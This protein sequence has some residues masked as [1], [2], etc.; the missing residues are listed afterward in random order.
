MHHHA[1]RLNAVTIRRK[2]VMLLHGW[3]R[4]TE[5]V[6]WPGMGGKGGAPITF[7]VQFDWAQAENL[8]E[9][10]NRGGGNPKD[11]KDAQLHGGCMN[12]DASLQGGGG[13]GRQRG[14]SW[15]GQWST[16][17]T[18]ANLRHLGICS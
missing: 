8:D 1:A 10:K 12:R 14:V 15:Q 16:G 4:A 5:V 7:P 6:L 13:N 11:T 2:E 9:D 3:T 17:M 18:P